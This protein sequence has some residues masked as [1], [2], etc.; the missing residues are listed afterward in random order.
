LLDELGALRQKHLIAVQN[1]VTA[2]NNNR[3]DQY[4][5]SGFRCPS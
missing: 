4:L 5:K 1:L 3:V 2:I